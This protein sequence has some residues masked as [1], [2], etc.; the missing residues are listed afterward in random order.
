MTGTGIEGGAIPEDAIPGGPRGPGAGGGGRPMARCAPVDISTIAVP[1]FIELEKAG[2]GAPRGPGGGGGGAVWTPALD[3]GGGGTCCEGGPEDW[4]YPPRWNGNAELGAGAR[5]AAGGSGAR[6]R[7]NGMNVARLPPPI[8]G[9]MVLSPSTG[10]DAPGLFQA[11]GAS[12]SP[13]APTTRPA[14]AG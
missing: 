14:S 10:C 1:S 11:A 12:S 2:F 8:I 4:P 7:A 6:P 9:A 3:G 13:A 5:G